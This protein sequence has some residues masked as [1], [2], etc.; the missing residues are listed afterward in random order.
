MNIAVPREV[1]EGENRVSLIPEHVAKL[2]KAGADFFGFTELATFVDSWPHYLQQNIEMEL[3]FD[4]RRDP[5]RNRAVSPLYHLDRVRIPLQIQQGA[6]DS[7]VPREQSDRLVQR[8]RNSGR[9][10]EY[11]VYAD[12][13]HGLTRF[14][15]QRLAYQRLVDFFRRRLTVA[16][17]L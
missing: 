11:F 6:N 17:P 4:P 9:M 5:V 15:N 14:E 13:G 2:V 16:T 1:H 12:E 7:R 8:L 10:V 3:G